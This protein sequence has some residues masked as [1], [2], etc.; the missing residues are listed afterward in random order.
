MIRSI[1]AGLLLTAVPLVAAAGPLRTSLAVEFALAVD[2]PGAAAAPIVRG[3][4]I[5]QPGGRACARVSQPVRQEMRLGPEG[6]VLVWPDSSTRLKIAVLP[7]G[8]PP[9]FE[10]LLVAITDPAAALPKGSTLQSRERK[11]DTVHSRWRVALGVPDALGQTG[12]LG[13]LHTAEDAQ[14]VTLIELET[15]KGVLQ[16]RFALGARSVRGQR[17]PGSVVAEF[18]G[19]KGQFARRERWTLQQVA[20][21]ARDLLP[22]AEAVKGQVL[23]DL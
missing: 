23:T 13:T 7:G 4:M 20:V 14:G 2:N 9:A 12:T 18:Y 16:K 8:V 3:R 21:L 5:L 6:A 11:G 15:D 22:C 17:L 1:L 19:K 10:A